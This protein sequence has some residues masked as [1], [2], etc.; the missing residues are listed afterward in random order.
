MPQPG[1]RVVYSGV[2]STPPT[3][4]QPE[5]QA[6]PAQEAPPTGQ[7]LAVA[8]A[9]PIS[10]EDARNLG[11]LTWLLGLFFSIIGPLIIWLIKRDQ[12]PFVDQVGK[13]VLN[14]N[15]SYTIWIIVT[16]LLS[17]VLIGLPFLLAAGVMYLVFS[18]VGAVKSNQG[19]LF[20]PWLTIRFLQ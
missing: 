13:T 5:A 9:Q 1:L 2:V 7:P 18:I 14:F 4:E 15:I 11:V 6:P 10:D 3:P 17:I 20:T 12:S 8:A 16:A 19:E